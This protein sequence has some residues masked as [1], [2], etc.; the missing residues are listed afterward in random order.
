MPPPTRLVD[1]DALSRQQTLEELTVLPLL[2][3]VNQAAELLGIGRSTLY[4]LMDAGE[5]K[6]VKRGASRRVPLQAV[7][8]YVDRLL[9]AEDEDSGRRSVFQDPA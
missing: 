1:L 3:T 4:E 5:L 7:H 6:S 9:A 8:D 2:L